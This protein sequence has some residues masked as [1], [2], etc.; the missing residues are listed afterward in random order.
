[1]SAGVKA[2]GHVGGSRPTTIDVCTLQ[3]LKYEFSHVEGSGQLVN[4]TTA[5][6]YLSKNSGLQ[7]SVKHLQHVLLIFKKNVKKK[8]TKML[9]NDELCI[10][11]QRH[12]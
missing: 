1:M 5:A 7:N 9:L 6:S 8:W 4:C 3:H 11:G 12:Q 2:N 10:K